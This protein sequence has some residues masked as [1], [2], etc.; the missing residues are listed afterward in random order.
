MAR[1]TK[2][3]TKII[4]KICQAIADGKSLRSIC[5]NSKMPNKS[6]IFRWLN[7]YP[8]FMKEYQLAVALRN[9]TYTDKIL[10]IAD[11]ADRENLEV[12]KL[13]IDSFK[14]YLAKLALKA[15]R[16]NL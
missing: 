3:N 15:H 13:Q 4:S 14:W 2:Y 5:N 7:I 10:E 16:F 1:P 8:E 9:E 12:S 6:T 11:S